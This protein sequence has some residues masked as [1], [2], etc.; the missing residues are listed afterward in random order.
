MPGCCI[1]GRHDAAHPLHRRRS[2]G[3]GGGPVQPPDGGVRGHYRFR[4]QEGLSLFAPGKFDVLITDVKMP[5]I[6]G[7]EVLRRVRSADPD[8]PVLVITAFGNMETAVEAMKEGACYFLGKPFDRGHLLVAIEEILGRR[9][10]SMRLGTF[11]VAERDRSGD[12]C[13]FPSRGGSMRLRAVDGVREGGTSLEGE[14]RDGNARRDRRTVGLPGATY[15]RRAGVFGG[16][17]DVR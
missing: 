2:C 5:G 14:E 15:G 8:I 7:I 10:S 17:P 16:V 12:L 6:S 9:A 11:G 1:R 3:E 13:V 4:R